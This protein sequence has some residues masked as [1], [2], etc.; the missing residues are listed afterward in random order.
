MLQIGDND[1]QF[2]IDCRSLTHDD[3]KHLQTLLSNESI[4][5]I[6]HNAKFDLNFGIILNL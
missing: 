5:K 4:V 2:V 6:L 3:L 1:K